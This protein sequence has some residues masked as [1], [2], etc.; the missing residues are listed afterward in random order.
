[1]EH[2]EG[3]ARQIVEFLEGGGVAMTGRRVADVG[4]GDGIID[5]GLAALA[6]PARLVGYDLRRTDE[7]TL[8]TLARRHG[9][10]DALP[11][12]LT[13]EESGVAAIP[14]PDDAFD[15]VVSWS[16]FEHISDPVGVLGEI[17]RILAPD[18]VLFLQLWPFFHSERGSHLW[19]WY[20]EGF[21]HLGVH[22]DDVV[23]G[24]RA[25]ERFSP[26]VVEYMVEEF[27]HLNRIT[28]DE[29]QRSLLAAGLVVRR[30]ELLTNPVHVPEAAHR[31]RLSDLGI[32]G[33]KLLATI[34]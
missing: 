4:C 20:P 14:A 21:H 8:L 22:E 17:R 31:F 3:A 33:I 7:E 1:M 19:E 11:G 13:F 5:L 24:M 9:V 25:D 15:V 28:V 23:A 32:A 30:F 2:Y 26:E 27:R 29:L 10:A 34:R 6:S 16:A 18:G 12:L